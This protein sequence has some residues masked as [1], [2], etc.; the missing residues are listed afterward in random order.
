M[1]CYM[2]FL[3]RRGQRIIAP[4]PN[5]G[6]WVQQYDPPS[7]RAGMNITNWSMIDGDVRI[8]VAPD[9]ALDLSWASYPRLGPWANF[10]LPLPGRQK[11]NGDSLADDHAG[12]ADRGIFFNVVTHGLDC[13]PFSFCPC[14]G[15]KVD[16][17]CFL[18]LYPPEHSDVRRIRRI[19]RLY[20]GQPL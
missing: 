4:G 19:C 13:G 17:T 16:L 6:V 15:R 5:P 12:P 9:G 11:G 8:S 14:R 20:P 2:R 1:Y 3:P 10:I 18:S 7:R